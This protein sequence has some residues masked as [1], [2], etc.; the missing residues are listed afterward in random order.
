[1]V[2]GLFID[3]GF[4]RPLGVDLQLLLSMLVDF[5]SDLVQVF[6][7]P[8]L[9]HN[10]GQ[11]FEVFRKLLVNIVLLQLTVRIRYICLFAVDPQQPSEQLYK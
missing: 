4:C 5:P 2:H 9:V 6:V 1:M 11:C 7:S 3:S 8:K 10:V